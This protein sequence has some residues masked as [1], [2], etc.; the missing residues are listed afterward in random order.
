MDYFIAILLFLLL[1]GIVY[2]SK[3]FKK[4]NFK[5]YVFVILFAIKLF[6]G[7]SLYY[8]YSNF[9]DTNTADIHKY[10]EGGKVLFSA[11]KESYADYF[12]LV[13]GIQGNKEHLKKYYDKTDHWTR[14]YS[15]GL[16]NDS[17]TVMRFN[18][19]LCLVSRGNV[20][21][22]IIIMAF[23]SF[24]GCFAL[25]KSVEKLTGL[26]KYLNVFASFLIP[27]CIFWT[28]GL[29]KEGLVMFSLGFVFYYMVKLY[30]KFN[31]FH[32]LIF[33]V[34]LFLLGISKIYVLPALLPVI[35][36][37][38]VGKN[39]NYKGQII[40]FLTICLICFF[41]FTFS[42]TLF[43]Y[44]IISTI[45]GKQNDFINYTSLEKN[46]GSNYN[47]TRLEPSLKSFLKLIPEGLINSF[48]RPFPT[49]INSFFLLL[50]FIEVVFLALVILITIF[51]FQKPSNENLRFI[52]FS[53]G[54]VM[55]LFVI[56]GIST[57]NSGALVR[58]RSFGLPF[59]YL[60]LFSLWD[61]GK[62]VRIKVKLFR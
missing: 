50:S 52:L 15:Y 57:P 32:L 12:R 31:I 33:L 22:H 24:I 53:F 36:F 59:L 1:S 30:F 14:K 37:F 18:A 43:G 46:V 11:S 2:F 8:I 27:S 28:S 39:F 16:Y 5:N 62:L 4:L 10:F 35:I 48:F 34:F 20:F 56:V 23:L 54:F 17:R 3:Y 51:L 60:M 40:S 26:N 29:L 7:L 47:L 44:D 45:S 41:A 38:Y 58:Y 6:G 25:F 49:E 19:I 21:V 55:F 9:Y 61:L 13:T 42:E